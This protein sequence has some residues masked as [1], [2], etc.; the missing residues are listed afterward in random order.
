MSIY[1]ESIYFS[2][3]CSESVKIYR[4]GILSVRKSS[5]K[6]YFYIQYDS[7]LLYKRYTACMVHVNQSLESQ[8]S[9]IEG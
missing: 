7:M 6:G 5:W 1:I 9:W 2:S 8:S 4:A 3:F